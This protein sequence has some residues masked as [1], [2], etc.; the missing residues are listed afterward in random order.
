MLSKSEELN[1][2][3]YGQLKNITELLNLDYYEEDGY[4]YILNTDNGN[5][6]VLKN[7]D[8]NKY[9]FTIEKDLELF[10]VVF[11]NEHISIHLNNQIFYMDESNLYYVNNGDNEESYLDL[12]NLGD[13]SFH[14]ENNDE[15]KDIIIN[16]NQ[17]NEFEKITLINKSKDSIGIT[18]ERIEIV[19]NPYTIANHYIHRYDLNNKMVSGCV[20]SEDIFTPLN[21]Y[22]ENELENNETIM[23]IVNE[24][25]NTI[26][27]IINY[28]K[29]KFSFL[30]KIQK[31]KLK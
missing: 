3:L 6:S 8:E 23:E 16:I 21:N 5:T 22:I 11:N 28:N 20:Y 4:I 14:K 30:E 17:D 9:S 18:N 25:E 31:N 29:E 15:T 27:G 2:I 10:T 13:Y 26:P 24:M 12:Y 19:E 1:T 7:K